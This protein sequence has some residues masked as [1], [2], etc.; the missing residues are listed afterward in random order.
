MWGYRWSAGTNEQWEKA[1][2][3]STIWLDIVRIGQEG[4]FFFV[5]VCVLGGRRGGKRQE[6]FKPLD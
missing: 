2:D 6:Q 3:I 4:F 5:C 1:T